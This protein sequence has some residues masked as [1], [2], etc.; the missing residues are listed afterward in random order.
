L[1][2]RF[3]LE[4]L[5]ALAD[6]YRETGSRPHPRHTVMLRRERRQG[7]QVRRVL[8]ERMSGRDGDDP[9]ASPSNT[10]PAHG[11]SVT[12]RCEL[13]GW[14]AVLDSYPAMVEAYQDH[15]HDEHPKAWLRA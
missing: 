6:L 10:D 5:D 14:Y 3:A 8:S 11:G 12:G 4:V 9:S 2:R 7:I 13:C 15:L 1:T